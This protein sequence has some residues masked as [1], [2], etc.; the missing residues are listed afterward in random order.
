MNKVSFRERFRQA[1]EI[2]N[3]KA[4]D[5][6]EKTGISQST[7]SQYLSGYSTPKPDRLGLIADALDVDYAWLLGFRV[8]MNAMSFASMED[9]DDWNKHNPTLNEEE[10]DIIHAYRRANTDIKNATCAVLGVRRE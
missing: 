1:L 6:S 4:V 7:L 2:R 9:C 3:M 8:P 10:L 5:I